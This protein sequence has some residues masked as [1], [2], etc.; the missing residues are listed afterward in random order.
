M[1]DWTKEI[2][3]LLLSRKNKVVTI[4]VDKKEVEYSKNLNL[5]QDIKA[6]RG[7]Y[8]SEEIV[9]AFLVDK[10]VN[11]IGYIEQNIEIEKEYTQS[12]IG[13]DK[14]NK[15]TG[16]IDVLV[17]DKSG[18]PFLFIE[19]KAPHKFEED[20][21]EIKG[22]LFNLSDEEE[23]TNKTKVHYL[24]YY[25]ID[26]VEDKIQDNLIIIDKYATK[27]YDE[28]EKN[29]LLS[30]GDEIPY[31]YGKPK[32]IIRKKDRKDTE[33]K[34]ITK[35]K[36]S[37]L[38][39][40]I[41]NTLWSS[42]VED[43]EAYLFLIKYL[44]TKIYDEDYTKVGED[45]VCQ[46]LD[47]D[48]DY[49]QS[50][51]DRIN[52][53][54]HEALEKKLNYKDDELQST[55]KII[56]TEKVS[57]ESLYFLTELLEDYS[58][59]KSLRN[60]KEDILG[61][62]FEDTNREKFKQSKGQFFTTT[63]IVNFIIY[64][65]QIDKLALDVFARKEE[66][67]YIIDPSTGSGTFLIEAMKAITKTFRKNEINLSNAELRTY[68]RLF[69]EDKPNEW[70]EKYIYGIDNNYSLAIST[71]VN[72]ILHGDGSSNIFKN[73]G[74]A[75]LQTYYNLKGSKLAEINTSENHYTKANANILVNERFDAVISNPPFSVTLAEKPE[76]INKFFLFGDKKNSE[77]LFIERWYQ[78]LNE[79]G[80]L[81]VVLPESVF[82]TT[83]NKYI[84]LFLFKYF[85]IKAVVSLPQ[86][87]F[88]PYTSTKT[89]LLF[90]QKKT[91]SEVLAWDEIWNKYANEW[92]KL[93]RRVKNYL[94]ILKGE[95]EKRFTSINKD[96]KN[97]IQKATDDDKEYKNIV[98]TLIEI[99][100][101]NKDEKDFE[102]IDE[103][104]I[105]AMPK[106]QLF[107]MFETEIKEKQFL[108][109][110]QRFLKDFLTE[111]DKKLTLKELLKKYQT[112]IDE[113]VIFDKSTIEI[114][115]YVNT[116][117][118]FGEV[119]KELEYNI[120][121]A[122]AENVGYK[123][124]TRSE[125]TMPNDLYDLEIAPNTVQSD[126]IITDYY[127]R[128]KEE[129]TK[130]KT[131]QEKL[132][133]LNKKEET[134]RTQNDIKQIEQT[135]EY[136]EVLKSNI[137]ILKNDKQTVIEIIEKY[138]SYDR[139]KD[140]YYDRT[141]T[142]LL[143]HFQNGLLKDYRSDDVLLRKTVAINILDAIRK[144]V[145]W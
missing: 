19:V 111:D 2:E 99:L 133:K 46:I 31:N 34:P 55:G 120:F 121:M 62:F 49:K 114:C 58:F 11:E 23:K 15:N 131:Q 109:N 113:L 95:S 90:A 71:K 44:L 76:V 59:T 124:T 112:E 21:K 126:K 84:R 102:G 28:W 137:E 51:L 89:S 118:V 36:L 81:G 16:R 70:A 85:T 67:P 122:E 54:Y 13:R 42:G 82:D 80:R 7:D 66:L 101:L 108:E 138:Y 45:Y 96:L 39:T 48:Y 105:S 119:A 98:S 17:K 65:L 136:T 8:F 25:S 22:Q 130:L 91:K 33:L 26:F 83:E 38:R 73:D 60:S 32:R 18:N 135:T 88:E 142:E 107:E 100:K 27:T 3:K 140:E 125:K 103:K 4:D 29:H 9:R 93:A 77:N 106:E 141:D 5:H 24:V 110:T 79:G 132:D 123:R 10:L 37:Q 87:A 43:N 128:I 116:W 115:G 144:E 78:L 41:H 20:K 75:N 94:K 14:Q 6:I 129:E 145:I 68:K 50:F 35:E 92:A 117:W 56:S 1:K 64:G 143:D 74:L 30:V 57:I 139:I 127:Q 86:L 61:A 40:Q 53:R 63:N 69:P 104:Q 52:T 12:S 134:K 97:Y 47:K 72:M